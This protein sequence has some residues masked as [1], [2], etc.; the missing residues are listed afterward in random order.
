VGHVNDLG[1]DRMPG[2]FR[3][4]HSIIEVASRVIRVPAN[5]C[6]WPEADVG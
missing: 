1:S 2:F 6:S 3:S 4:G 5:G